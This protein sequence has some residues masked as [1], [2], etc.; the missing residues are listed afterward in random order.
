M[1]KFAP[2]Q[3]FK[4]PGVGS[5]EIDSPSNFR[6]EQHVDKVGYCDTTEDSMLPQGS[7]PLKARYTS[8][9]YLKDLDAISIPVSK[10][11]GCPKGSKLVDGK[12]VPDSKK[13]VIKP[14]SKSK[15]QKLDIEAK[16]PDVIAKELPAEK[17]KTGVETR[18]VTRRDTTEFT[19][20]GNEIYRNK[21]QEQKDAQ[22]ARERKRLKDSERTVTQE[23]NYNIVNGKKVYIGGFKD[24]T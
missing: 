17:L 2:N 23:R 13:Q 19:K 10:K 4:M 20:A 6:D 15:T 5:K 3:G 7:S 8:S 12:C 22:D 24:K 1:P 14:K 16:M 21:T 18:D 11:S 9:G